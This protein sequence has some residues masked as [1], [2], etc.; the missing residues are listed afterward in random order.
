MGQQAGPRPGFLLLPGAVSVLFG[1]GLSLLAQPTWAGGPSTGQVPPAGS[2]APAGRARSRA[3]GCWSRWCSCSPSSRPGVAAAPAGRTV[4][5]LAVGTS[6]PGARVD[7][8]PGRTGRRARRHPRPGR[9]SVGRCSGV[10]VLSWDGTRE[11]AAAFSRTALS[12]AAD[13]NT[14]VLN[15]ALHRSL[16]DTTHGR[17]VLAKALGTVALLAFGWVHRRQLAATAPLEC[18]G[19][20]HLPGR[21]R[22][23]PGGGRGHRSPGRQ[24][25]RAQAARSTEPV[26]MVQTGRR[27]DGA[28]GGLAGRGRSQRRPR[29]LPGP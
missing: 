21:G 2:S 16:T 10:L 13:R 20:P 4:G 23:R 17:L 28:H 25:R 29:L 11:R 6:Q 8:E 22:R 7:C 15:A 5:I 18:P 3:C 24:C 26:Q 14:G 12:R 19:A 9:R 27:H 1:V